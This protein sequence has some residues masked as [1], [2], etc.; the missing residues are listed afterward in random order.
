MAFREISVVQIR[1][2]IRRWLRGEGERRIARAIGVDRKTARRYIA[3]AISVGL[4]RTGGDGQLTDELLGCL[5]EA[6]RLHRSDGH[7]AAWRSLLAEEQQIKGWVK[8]GLTVVKI[9]I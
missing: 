6:V 1:E 5:V 4:E 2:A 3:A 9:G 8:D 7:G